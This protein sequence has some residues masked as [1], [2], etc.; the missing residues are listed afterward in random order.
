MTHDSSTFI[1]RPGTYFFTVRLRDPKSDLLVAHIDLLRQ[2]FRSCRQQWPFEMGDSVILPNRMHMIWTL[3]AQDPDYGK[4]WKAI[5]T[6]FARHIPSPRHRSRESIEGRK[7]G[8]W[9]RRFWENPIRDV[10]DLR[11]YQQAIRNAPVED[12][13]VK[14]PEAWPYASYSKVGLPILAVAS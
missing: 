3:P 7:Q 8:I 2:S 5:K 11:M 12:G 9:Q 13:L 10:S 6:T 1:L 4:R 14:Q